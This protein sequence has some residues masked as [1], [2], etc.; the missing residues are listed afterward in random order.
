MNSL[1]IRED[2]LFERISALIEEARK[3]VKTAI[4]T[5]MVYTYYGIGQYIVDDEQQGEQR[6]QYGQA[7]LKKLSVRLTDKYGEGWSL[8]HLKNIRQFYLTYSKRLNT[9]YPID[10]TKAKQCI[11]NSPK[12]VN[13]VDDIDK[14]SNNIL[15][16]DNHCLSN[17]SPIFTLSWSHYLILMRIENPDNLFDSKR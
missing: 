6:A 13:S 7:V 10:L 5:T 3:R 4:D 17:S 15:E 9:V 11:A 16:N 1:Q 12:I 14:G 8:P 2:S